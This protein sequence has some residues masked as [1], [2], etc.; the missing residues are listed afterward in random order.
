M[1]RPSSVLLVLCAA[2]SQDYEILRG[3][4]DVDPGSVT[5]CGFT[6]VPG[7]KISAYDCNPVFA[8]TDEPWGAY[9]DGVG[10]RAQ[11]VLGHPF[12]QIWYSARPTEAWGDWSIG[13]AISGN[14][15]DWESHPANP[16]VESEHG[17]DHD[18]ADAVQVLWDD[19][20]NQYVMA[21]QGYNID[22]GQWGM[23]VATSPDGVDWNVPANNKV[24]DFTQ[25]VGGVTYCWPLTVTSLDG[26]L[27]GFIAGQ[28]NNKDVCQI[29]PVRIDSAADWSPSNEVAVAAG[30]DRYDKAGMT[31]AAVAEYDGIYYMFYIG[32]EQWV[33]GNGYQSSNHHHFALATSEDGQNWIKHPKNPFDQISTQDDG[34]MT[35]VAAQ[36]VGSRIHLWITDYYEELDR[37][38]VGYFYFEP[39][40]EAWP[41]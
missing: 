41:E 21:Y 34:V 39:D 36:V 38:A 30:P 37:W 5:E 14:G 7:T 4:V 18:A 25:A 35:S 23:G 29:Y 17:W 3:P 16:L 26:R 24:L 28:P 1:P 32:F 6:P 22:N 10:F 31:S 9:V 12:Y 11:E 27:K 19:A 8:G 33:Q 40:I 20:S 2:C 15:T 13:Y